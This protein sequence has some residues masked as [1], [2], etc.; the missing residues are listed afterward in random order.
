ML[1]EELAKLSNLAPF[2]VDY[3]YS[4]CKDGKTLHPKLIEARVGIQQVTRITSLMSDRPKSKRKM[5]GHT[6][7]SS[8]LGVGGMIW[9]KLNPSEKKLIDLIMVGI[10]Q[11]LQIRDPEILFGSAL[12]ANHPGILELIAKNSC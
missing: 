12:D 3:G 4:I 8:R 11:K 2:Y 7:H 1:L 10:A 5:I 6:G 9:A